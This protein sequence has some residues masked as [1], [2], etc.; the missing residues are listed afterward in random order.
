MLKPFWWKLCFP[1]P[2]EVSVVLRTTRWRLIWFVL[3]SLFSTIWESLKNT[4]LVPTYLKKKWKGHV[5]FCCGS[6]SNTTHVHVIHLISNTKYSAC[7]PI[8]KGKI[9][10]WDYSR[11]N[12]HFTPYKFVIWSIICNSN[13][14]A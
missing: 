13:M 9:Q 2:G 10:K 11:I 3:T 4:M 5:I 12:I 7:Y 6:H 8:S 14:Y 1:F